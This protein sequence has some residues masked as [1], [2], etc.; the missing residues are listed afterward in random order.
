MVRSTLSATPT[1]RT[2]NSRAT[3]PRTVAGYARA[4]TDT[5]LHCALQYGHDIEFGINFDAPKTAVLEGCEFATPSGAV[6]KHS[7]ATGDITSGGSCANDRAEV[8]M[9][10][11]MTIDGSPGA[12]DI[13]YTCPPCGV[14]TAGQEGTVE[15]RVH[16]AHRVIYSLT[17]LSKTLQQAR[18]D[19]AV[20]MAT[21]S[22]AGPATSPHA[23]IRVQPATLESISP[24]PAR[25]RHSTRHALTA[26]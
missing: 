23:A 9:C 17:R 21:A 10:S 4:S 5:P 18:I 15:A 2:A 3:R 8:G 22:H 20:R 7:G 14:C 13:V 6:Y 1:S 25:I 11:A 19:R 24:T 16:A 26:M 12:G